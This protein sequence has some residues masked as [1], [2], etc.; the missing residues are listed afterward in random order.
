MPETETT[1]I[2]ES[3]RQKYKS[4]N[5]WELI[6]KSQK[7]T[8]TDYAC[9]CIARVVLEEIRRHNFQGK[10]IDIPTFDSD[11]GHVVVILEVAEKIICLNQMNGFEVTSQ[12]AIEQGKDVTN[13]IMNA[14]WDQIL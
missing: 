13:E 10:L 1:K 12:Q 3:F 14:R 6:Q 4:K 5:I 11:T 9:T 8:D 7:Y 2:V